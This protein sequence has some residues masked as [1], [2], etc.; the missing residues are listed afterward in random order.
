MPPIYP[1]VSCPV[2]ETRGEKRG[3]SGPKLSRSELTPHCPQYGYLALFAP[4]YP[5]APFLALIDVA[6]TIRIDA[7]NFCTQLRRS[8]WRPCESIGSWF[9]VLNTLGFVAVMTNCTMIAFVGQQLAGN[10]YEEEG[11]WIKLRVQRLWTISVALEHAMVLIRVV[12]LKLEPEEPKWISEKQDTLQFRIDQWKKA[13]KLMQASNM[14]L[15]EIHL[16]MYT[17]EVQ[18]NGTA[19]EVS[20]A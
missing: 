7:R 14:T 18:V 10:S 6:C 3:R 16:E 15:E 5:L 17:D 1:A 20:I 12:I 2:C 19:S 11:I 8:V 4:A 13:A 9:G